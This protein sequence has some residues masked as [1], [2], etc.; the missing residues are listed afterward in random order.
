MKD[1]AL[2]RQYV[3]HGSQAAFGEIMKRHLALVYGVCLREV[4]DPQ[5]AE[6]V[7]QGVFL[8]LARKA[9]SLEKHATLTGWLFRTACLASKDALRRERRRRRRER[10]AA[11]SVGPA[12]P[13]HDL[14]L[15]GA[16]DALKPADREAVLLRFFEGLSF[17]E[18]GQTLGVSEDAAQKRVARA[19]ERMRR[20]ITQHETAVSVAI[21]TGL[22]NAEA[23]R[24][25]PAYCLTPL[26]HIDPVSDFN[27]AAGTLFGTRAYHIAQGVLRT[28]KAKSA[29]TTAGVGVLAVAATSLL[30]AG[31]SKTGGN[32][33][34]TW[35]GKIVAY[36]Y[37]PVHPMRLGQSSTGPM[38]QTQQTHTV[39]TTWQFN[40]DGTCRASAV[41]T[42]WT[43]RYRFAGGSLVET[44]TRQTVYSQ[45][46]NYVPRLTLPANQPPQ[47]FA[48]TFSGGGKTL[49]LTPSGHKD[50]NWLV[51]RRQ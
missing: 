28:M 17:Q 51:L 43:G 23:T 9:A 19:V 14:P 22:L 1:G 34:G 10:E 24:S 46:P 39:D 40:S 30:M 2:L 8:V 20:Y 50:W 49:R 42:T 3:R 38:K 7:T 32:I 13:P 47:T 48:A 27:L 21:L 4:G 6:D 41:N 18:T 25:A 36:V 45:D 12:P 37:V 29:L 33:V 26:L 35:R 44:M 15:N 11:Q 16:L 31:V 5:M